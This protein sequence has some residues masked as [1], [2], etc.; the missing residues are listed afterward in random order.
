M[1]SIFRREKKTL[2]TFAKNKH[3]KNK[4]K[5]IIKKIFESYIDKYFLLHRLHN[6]LYEKNI[7]IKKKTEI[8]FINEKPFNK[9]SI[10]GYLSDFVYLGKIFKKLVPN[11][12][13]N[14]KNICDSM[15]SEQ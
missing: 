15:I 4:N 8:I 2:E 12:M 7:I 11:N 1:G 6:N 14:F 10:N 13:R 5:F 3:K 9:T